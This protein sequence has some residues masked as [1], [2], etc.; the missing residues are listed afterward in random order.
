VL[1]FD[2]VEPILESVVMQR[3]PGAATIGTTWWY[4]IGGRP[5]RTPRR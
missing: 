3:R 4:E 2:R 1:L 5:I